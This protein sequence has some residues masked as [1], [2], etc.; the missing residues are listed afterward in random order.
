MLKLK[1]E[2][3]HTVLIL[4]QSCP[5]FSDQEPA[6][7]ELTTGL[8]ATRPFLPDLLQGKHPSRPVTCER[9]LHGRQARVVVGFLLQPPLE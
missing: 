3:G 4:V 5:G 7:A 1:P 9:A 6:Q 2:L 8:L